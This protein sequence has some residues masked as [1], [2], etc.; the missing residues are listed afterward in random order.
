MWKSIIGLVEVVLFF[1]SPI[2]NS[3]VFAN[4]QITPTSILV[5][6]LFFLIFD[7]LLLFPLFDSSLSRIFY[8]GKIFTIKYK[9]G[10]V[11][12]KSSRF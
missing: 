10:G 11:K 2:G 1:Y 9:V 8:I 12:R 7:I 5:I 6:I 4:R 3:T